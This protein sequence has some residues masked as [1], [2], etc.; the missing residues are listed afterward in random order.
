MFVAND[1][2]FLV[3]SETDFGKLDFATVNMTAFKT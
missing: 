3:F 1:N 2:K